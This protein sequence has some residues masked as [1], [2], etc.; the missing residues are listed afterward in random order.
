ML[1]VI[2]R[3]QVIRDNYE[4]TQRLAIHFRAMVC[5]CRIGLQD[6][7]VVFKIR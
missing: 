7:Y 1:I 5:T 2:I 6:D 3:P 4:K